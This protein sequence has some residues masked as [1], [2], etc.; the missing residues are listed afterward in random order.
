MKISL[1]WLENYVKLGAYKKD[2][3][4]LAHDLTMRGLE[5]S[6]VTSTQA[7]WTHVVIGKINKIEKHPNAD[8]LVVCDVTDG[9]NTYQVVCGAK[10]ISEG[11]LVPFAKIGAKLPGN[12]EIKQAK[13][14]GVDSFGMLCSQKELG[15]G[16]DTAGIFILPQDAKLGV[17]L[18]EFLG[19]GDT[20]LEV[21]VTA[22]RGDCLSHIGLAREVAALN[23][24]KI[25]RPLATIKFSQPGVQKVASV[26]IK[27]RECSRY[28]AMIVQDVHVKPSPPWMQAYLRAVGLRPIN[29]IVDITNFIL[30][31]YG[32]PLHAFD[33]DKLSGKKIIVRK[34]LPDEKIKTL[35]GEMRE[36][37]PNDIVIADAEKAVALGGVMG[38]FDSQVT[39]QT[40]NILIES[41]CFEPASIRKTSKRLKLQ[42]ESSYRFERGV[43]IEGVIHAL[44]RAASLSRELGDGKV[45]AGK[46]DTYPEK[47]KKKE[48]LLS[49]VFVNRFIGKDIPVKTIKTILES[50]GFVVRA[51]KKDLWKV[52]VPSFR[53]DVS[54]QADLV[55][56]I[57]RSI[58]LDSVPLTSLS[59]PQ[60]FQLKEILD[61]KIKKLLAAQGFHEAM[62][63][64]FVSSEL[65][66]SFDMGDKSH[67]LLNPINEDFAHLRPVLFP[68]L[69]KNLAYNVHRNNK[70]V[71]LFEIRRVFNVAEN[72]TLPHEEEHLALLLSGNKNLSPWPESQKNYDFYDAKGAIEQVFESMG[73]EKN[74]I[75]FKDGKKDC[76]HPKQAAEV[77][78]DSDHVGY[79]GELHPGV[80]KKFD[81]E[82]TA[83]IAELFF[84]KLLH[85]AISKKAFKAISKFPS[86]TR[87]F[88]IVVD[89]SI[90]HQHVTKCLDEGNFELVQDYALFDVY[91]DEQNLGKDKKS[92]AYRVV[93]QSYEKTLTDEEIQ[94]SHN[95]ILKLLE[96]KLG[97]QVRS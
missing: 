36:L 97:A 10:N 61:F 77:F 78:V 59:A 16:D 5:V 26:T 49:R 12:F 24:T 8:K 46:I 79:M 43:D 50:F 47:S 62:N 87:D 75:E 93:Y 34:P 18:E 17:P 7:G 6:S 91:Q 58:G 90:T 1:A 3:H 33:F 20:V 14:R 84:S 73:I 53:L 25:Q 44:E 37:A 72:E 40:K 51:Q 48:I 67:K 41:A 80:L 15:M 38:G 68:S 27:H 76:L 71:K 52:G 19:A 81:L 23:K 83:Y 30:M 57:V 55:E 2:P 28:A 88:A 54:N 4:V 32:Q 13:L 42:S 45:L 92:L 82:Q 29:N 66:S 31:E 35:D 85:K 39:P 94:A 89:E 64:S 95:K 69:V 11:D 96:A 9:K 63:Y 86:V 74:K 56:E 60:D 65:L 70:S 21:E 22:N